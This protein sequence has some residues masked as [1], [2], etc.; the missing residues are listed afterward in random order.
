MVASTVAVDVVPVVGVLPPTTGDDLPAMLAF[1]H[2]L[3]TSPVSHR[4]TP[5][6]P[7]QGAM[8]CV[9]VDGNHGMAVVP[10]HAA[11]LVDVAQEP[12]EHQGLLARRADHVAAHHGPVASSTIAGS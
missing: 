10:I 7:L 6:R 4:E 12:L 3:L 1:L 5:H 2:S 11:G 8:R 9:T